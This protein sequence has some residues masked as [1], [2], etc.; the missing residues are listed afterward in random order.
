MGKQLLRQMLTEKPKMKV[1]LIDPRPGLLP[2]F[3]L[4]DEQALHFQ[5]DMADMAMLKQANIQK[6][7]LVVLSAREDA[8]NLETAYKVLQL[9]PDVPIWVRLHHSGL[10]ELLELSDQPNIHFFCPYQQA[11]QAIVDYMIEK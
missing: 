10:A 4:T 5:G 3:G 8:L 7:S 2:E 11:A 6:A 1:V 9:N